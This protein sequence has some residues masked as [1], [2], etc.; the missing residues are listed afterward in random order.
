MITEVEKSRNLTLRIAASGHDEVG[1][2]ADAFNRLMTVLQGALGD[3]LQNV[4]QVSDAAH[5]LSA[6]A[7]EVAISSAQQSEATSVM[8]A[9]VEEVTV[10]INQ[11]SDNARQAQEISGKTGDLSGNIINSTATEMGLIADSVNQTSEIIGQLGQQSNQISSV[12]QVIKAVAEQTNLLALNAAIEAA[13]AGEQG[14][15]FA[16]VADEVRKLAE[17][18]TNATEEISGVIAVIQAS[19]SKAV[20]SMGTAVSQVNSSV[21]LAQQA[22]ESINQIR[23]GAAQVIQVVND[24]SSALAE[25]SVASNDI[26]ANVE[27]VARMSEATRASTGETAS[28]ANHL[29]QLADTMR[30]AVS[31]F[32][33]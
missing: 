19:T 5:M 21:A 16:V 6:S 8:A 15:G 20:V 17:R 26:A 13:R 10:S 11:V 14:R 12:V 7:E 31:Q 32:K 30:I 2:T 22:G 9:T 29:N 25:Q 18:T 27:R 3:I 24:I 33:I 1:Q 23:E 28:A 4:N